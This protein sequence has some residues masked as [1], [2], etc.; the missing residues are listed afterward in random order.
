VTPSALANR[1]S[2][3]RLTC[4]VAFVAMREIVRRLTPE[5]RASSLWLMPCR[6][7]IWVI[8]K[9]VVTPGNMATPHLS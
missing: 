7:R 9:V 6:A 3:S 1:S 8:R 4:A 5:S 2:V